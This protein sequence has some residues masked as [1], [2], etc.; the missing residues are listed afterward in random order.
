MIRD[1]RIDTSGFCQ[2]GGVWLN[3][4]DSRS[5]GTYAPSPVQ[6]R[7]LA[8]P[9]RFNTTNRILFEEL[10]RESET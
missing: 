6:I 5:A 8:H 7:A 4:A 10:R 2:R 3:A 9:F 1:F